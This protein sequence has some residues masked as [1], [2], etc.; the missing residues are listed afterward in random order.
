MQMASYKI[1]SAQIDTLFRKQY[2]LTVTDIGF[3]DDMLIGHWKDGDEAQI[4]VDWFANKFNLV[5][6]YHF[7][8]F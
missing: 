3:S 4:F 5:S 8:T 2:C 7:S 6:L 1:W